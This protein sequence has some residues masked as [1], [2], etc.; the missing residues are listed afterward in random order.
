MTESGPGEDEIASKWPL[1]WMIWNNDHK[2]LNRL[3]EQ[4]VYDK[5]A[6]DPRGRTP[7][8]LATTLGHRDCMEIMMYH[9]ADTMATNR[10]Q[11]SVFHE[12][13]CTGNPDI[14]SMTMMVRDKQQET[15]IAKDIPLML[16]KL[17]TSPDFYVEMK[18][19]FTS[20][21]PFL[22]RVCPSDTYKI[23]KKGTNVRV[24]TSLVGFENM[25]WLRGNQSFI[26][27]VTDEGAK[28]TEIDHDKMSVWE[29]PFKLTGQP[30]Q[31]DAMG[32]HELSAS[33][34]LA[35]P[36]VTTVF[37]TNSIAFQRQKAGIWGFRS[38]R[39]EVV[40]DY[41]TKVFSAS[42][43]DLVTRTRVDHLPDSEKEKHKSAS[44]NPLQGI[45]A[46][47]ESSSET[48]PVPSTVRM[49]PGSTSVT[50]GSDDT[51]PQLSMSEYFTAPSNV[52]EYDAIGRPVQVYSRVQSLKA[53]VWLSENHP[54][55]LQDQLMP[56]IE[57]MALNNAHFAKLKDFI[58]LQMPAGFPVKF[59][60]PLFHVM[61][62]RVTFGNV[63]GIKQPIP[64]VSL[65]SEE[66]PQPI[67]SDTSETTSTTGIS[68]I[69]KRRHHTNS[70][71]E[72]TS[73][74]SHKSVVPSAV[75]CQI[76]NREICKISN[77]AFEVPE[78]YRTHHQWRGG[79]LADEEEELLQ[80]A[81]RQSLMDQTS[82]VDS[83]HMSLVEAL[84]DDTLMSNANPRILQSTS[85]TLDPYV[86]CPSSNFHHQDYSN[87][88]DDDM[89]LALALSQAQAD[90][91]ERK[92][93]RQE[94]EE[95]EL[96]LKLS[97]EEK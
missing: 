41:N 92:R 56:V 96:V 29:H 57:L 8:H 9:G 90:E 74:G 38:D 79:T 15:Q 11:W 33:Q 21:I 1:H 69:L 60:I 81:I 22:S 36:I 40:N 30:N 71:S 77:E 6:K 78:R 44:V 42:G 3:L 54:L 16:E 26:F 27:Q 93:I 12:A 37:D 89:A 10:H 14:V 51:K 24:D 39:T 18:W 28:L 23:W 65:E 75:P 63:N 19:E 25:Q 58:T 72:D 87:D 86:I 73:V 2:G 13:I 55:S 4:K 64:Y 85:S 49:L 45:L 95:L 68:S 20:W 62:A 84:R 83:E 52:K 31:M 82:S 67:V 59:E 34:R 70:K 88:D 50:E 61:S 91:D 32:S 5:E 17:Q 47:P 48:A 76:I 53:N 35:S 46:M 94:D 80:L 43:L 7:L 97:L 66:V